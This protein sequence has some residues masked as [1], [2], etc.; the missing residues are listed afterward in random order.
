MRGP[1]KEYLQGFTLGI[2]L[3]ALLVQIFVMIML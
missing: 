1:T 3:C 2:A